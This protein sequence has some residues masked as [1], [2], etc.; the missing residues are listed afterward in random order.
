MREIMWWNNKDNTVIGELYCGRAIALTTILY[1]PVEYMQGI[2]AWTTITNDDIQDKHMGETKIFN[3]W[4]KNEHIVY[5]DQPIV[6]L[7]SKVEKLNK[8]CRRKA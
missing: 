8:E 6:D 4:H 5:Y 7:K 1:F 3:Y 2:P